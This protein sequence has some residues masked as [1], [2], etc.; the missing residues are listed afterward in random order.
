MSIARTMLTRHCLHAVL[1]FRQLHIR[2]VSHL[3]M[4]PAILP[5]IKCHK[6]SLVYQFLPGIHISLT[7]RGNEPCLFPLPPS[8]SSQLPL[9]VFLWL[10]AAQISSGCVQ[11]ARHFS[12][13]KTAR[14][15]SMHAASLLQQISCKPACVQSF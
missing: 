2:S 15:E 5:Y 14:K 7:A 12:N 10:A 3:V 6:L 11:I 8:F 4:D 9:S 1:N 13:R